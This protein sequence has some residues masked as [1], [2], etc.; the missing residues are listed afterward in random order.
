MTQSEVQWSDAERK[1]AE[2]ALKRA[3]RKD[4]EALINYVQTHANQI[5]EP[6]DVW[7]LHDFLSAKRHDIDGK[8]DDREAFLMFTLSKLIK[9][10]LLTLAE[11][12]GLTADKRAKVTVLTR[13]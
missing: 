2:D 8:Y 3:Y 7:Q 13:M 11:L 4:V 10:G 1:I 5:S 9:D 6:E 12:D